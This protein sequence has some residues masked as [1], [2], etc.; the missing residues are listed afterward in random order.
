MPAAI[1]MVVLVF[2]C[3]EEEKRLPVLETQEA[4]FIQQRSAVS[5][6]TIIDDGSIPV[7]ARG[8]CW[9]TSPAPTVNDNHTTDTGDVFV[10]TLTGLLP[11]TLY[12]VRAYATN[13]NGTGY[14]NEVT[15]E[16]GSIR[17][18]EVSTDPV[19]SSIT[20]TSAVSGGV[21]GY[22]GGAT[23]TAKG[24]CWNT[25]TGPTL[26]NPHT[27]DGE[28]ND[29]FVSRLSG[30]T[31]NTTYYVR[32]YATNST[33]TAYGNE[34]SFTTFSDSAGIVLFNPVLFN[35][36]LTYGKVT[37]AD[38]NDY[39]TIQTGTQTWMAE[40]LK[41]VTFRNGAQIANLEIV[42]A[43]PDNTLDA[44]CW[45]DNDIAFKTRYGALYNWYAVNSGILCPAGW[46]VPSKAEFETLITFLGG[47]NEAGGKL[48]ESITDH[49]LP[50]NT[51]S[52]N[53]S[54]FSALPAGYLSSDG[55]RSLRTAGYWW[56][57]SE[58]NSANASFMVTGSNSG[59]AITDSGSKSAGMS[60]RCI[61]D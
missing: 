39:K 34:L 29:H 1:L 9:N 45:Y 37:D 20:S 58:N 4:W 36:A 30:L 59:S 61:K 21:I 19:I 33:G 32:S 10:S 18:P 16:T 11:A 25:V 49:W 40:N 60:V 8:V 5:G 55:F 26:D 23:V 57:S 56:T 44:Y 35:P 17:V 42:S 41:T 50:P 12:Y 31:G 24:V 28:G 3:E 46:H 7:L 51:G 54:G 53:E 38:F 14:G 27:T 13:K 6:G 52:T 48:K 43:W 15:F 47:E 2:A 22:N